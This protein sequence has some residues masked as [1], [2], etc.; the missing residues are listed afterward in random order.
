MIEMLT[1]A[2]N[3]AGVAKWRHASTP[4]SSLIASGHVYA[5]YVKEWRR[6]RKEAT[7]Q[8][9][10]QIEHELVVELQTHLQLPVR[11]QPIL[12]CSLTK[13]LAKGCV[14]CIRVGH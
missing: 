8:L 1:D 13:H 12:A 4:Y 11:W 5:I 10:A 3:D 9:E 14:G 6:L 7:P 2:A